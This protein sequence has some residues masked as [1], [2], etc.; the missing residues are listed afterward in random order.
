MVVITSLPPFEKIK[1]KQF[2]LK[3]F[4]AINIDHLHISYFNS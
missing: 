3:S 2:Y 1:S 4:G